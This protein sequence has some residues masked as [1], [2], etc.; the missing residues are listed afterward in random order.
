MIFNEF[1]NTSFV[2]IFIR[3]TFRRSAKCAIKIKGY[4][5][6]ILRASKILMPRNNL[7][8]LYIFLFL[9]FLAERMCR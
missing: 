8:K 7:R 3:K 9:L 5:S 4:K 2:S 1:V 6:S